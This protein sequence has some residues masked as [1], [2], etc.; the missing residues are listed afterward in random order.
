LYDQSEIA[1]NI[2]AKKSIRKKSKSGNKKLEKISE[3]SLKELEEE[4]LEELEDDLKETIGGKL[5]EELCE[6]DFVVKLS[7]IV[8]DLA[9]NVS[10]KVKIQVNRIKEDLEDLFNK[11]RLKKSSFNIEDL[12]WINKTA[13]RIFKRTDSLKKFPLIQRNII[14][15]VCER[16]SDSYIYSQRNYYNENILGILSNAHLHSIISNILKAG[17]EFKLADL[18]KEGSPYNEFFKYST[19]ALSEEKKIGLLQ[20]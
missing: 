19:P 9:G 13:E 3:E 16:V 15:L 6:E 17:V 14:K 10:E 1:L 8:E 11:G 4:K 20:S 5:I 18:L 7:K 2:M 12:I